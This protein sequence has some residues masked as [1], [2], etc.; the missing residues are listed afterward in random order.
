MTTLVW[1]NWEGAKNIP[2]N[3]P[4]LMETESLGGSYQ[5]GRFHKNIQGQTLGTVGNY[6]AHDVKIYRW[7]SLKD[8]IG[9]DNI[10]ERGT[11]KSIK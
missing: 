7:A 3:E 4:L 8:I 10:S 6:F 9:Q 2:L 5:I 11:P 1:H